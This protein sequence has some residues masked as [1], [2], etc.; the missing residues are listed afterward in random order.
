MTIG[1]QQYLYTINSHP[2]TLSWR[3]GGAHFIS[4]DNMTDGQFMAAS[5]AFA[6][7][8][9]TVMSDNAVIVGHRL[10][11]AT[12]FVL[13]EHDFSVQG[14]FASTDYSE[15][16]MLGIH[17]L[18][19]PTTLNPSNRDYCSKLFVGHRAFNLYNKTKLL[20]VDDL[21]AALL[22][23]FTTPLLEAVYDVEEREMAMRN[24]LTPQYHAHAQKQYGS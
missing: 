6:D 24:Y 18:A 2:H 22:D 17:Y 4:A 11:A 9:K 20:A 10:L 12:G 13:R 5:A 3:I 16:A 23:F 8:L 19:T 21:P 1:F 7:R 15:S 14:E